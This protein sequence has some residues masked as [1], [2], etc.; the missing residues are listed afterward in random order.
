[1]RA[2]YLYVNLFDLGG[3]AYQNI[4]MKIDCK[5]GGEALTYLQRL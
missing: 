1:M 3:V 4:S 2:K 5:V